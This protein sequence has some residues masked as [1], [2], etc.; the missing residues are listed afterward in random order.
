MKIFVTSQNPVKIKSTENAFREC[1]KAKNISVDNLEIE[2]GNIQSNVSDQPSTDMETFQGAKNRV[3]NAIQ[4]GHIAD[5]YVGIESGICSFENQSIS[6]T[7]VVV[8]DKFGEIYFAKSQSYILPAQ[9]VATM[10]NDNLELGPAI[11]KIYGLENSKQGD[12]AVGVLTQNLIT[13]TK[14]TEEAIILALIN[15][16]FE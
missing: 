13:R 12:G 4:S 6:F 8:G 15:I 7:W 14:L 16:P 9:V 2:S 11:D 3:L 10:E 1:L 5:F